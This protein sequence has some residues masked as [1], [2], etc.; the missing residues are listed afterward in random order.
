M[1][2][3]MITARVLEFL[4]KQRFHSK[5]EMARALGIQ[6]RTLEKVFARLGAAKGST[7]A[8]SKALGYCLRNDVLIDSIFHEVTTKDDP[9]ININMHG[10]GSAA[11]HR[12]YLHKPYVLTANGE[13]IFSSMHYF[14]CCASAKVCPKC[15]TWCN[16]WN[17]K[18]DVSEIDCFIGHM[19][20]E[21][22]K[23]VAEFYTAEGDD[24]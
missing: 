23:D 9:S 5:A 2:E 16:P 6:Q 19:A 22:I 11:Y 1:D 7:I 12:L 3:N 21:I 4:L 8:L 24:G 18:R 13:R 10:N 17:G 15:G 20:R 14:L